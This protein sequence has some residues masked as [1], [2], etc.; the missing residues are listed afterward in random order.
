MS[1]LT[2]IIQEIF[3]EPNFQV[4]VYFMISHLNVVLTPT[5]FVLFQGIGITR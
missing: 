3:D 4:M 2:T 5:T 1:E